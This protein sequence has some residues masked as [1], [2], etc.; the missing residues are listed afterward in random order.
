MTRYTLL[1]TALAVATATAAFAAP[2]TPSGTSARIRMSLDANHDGAIDRSEAAAHPRLATKFDQLDKNRDGRLAADERPQ[3]R[4]RHGDHHGRSGGIA[5][6]DADGDGRLSRAELAGKETFAAKFAEVDGNRDGYLVRSELRNY[7]ERMRP[8]RQAEHAK[9]SDE[10]FAAAD[11]NRDGK[12]SKVEASEK[13]PRLA[14]GF[15]WMDENRDGFL[16]REELRP[17]RR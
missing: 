17:Q 8:Q 1:A 3:R 14:K 2:P 7:H 9:R 5:R 11:L 15:A 16:S 10:Q 12:I 13:L 6:L 4:G